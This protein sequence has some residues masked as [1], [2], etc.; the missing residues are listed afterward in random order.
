MKIEE[1]RDIIDC[2]P[3][4]RTKFYY[5]KD[6]YALMLLVYA[7]GDGMRIH[8]IKR[9]RFGRLIRKPMVEKIIRD[10]GCG[11]L[12]PRELGDF[13]PDRYH[14]Y[15]LTLG[16]WG[17]CK[18]WSRFYN[19]TSRPGWNLVLHLN[20][21]AE[22]NR[23]FY[24]LVKPRNPYVFQYL[25]HPVASSGRHTLAWARIDMDLDAGEALIEE[26]QT[27]WIRKAMRS[28]RIM[29]ACENSAGNRQRYIPDDVRNLGCDSV[30]L[31]R[32]LDLTLKPHMQVWDEAMLASAI[33]FLK[34]EIGLDRI[35]YHTFEFGSQWKRICGS[36]PPRSL[37]TKLP[38]R[39]C[40]T[41]TSRVPG[42]LKRKN[43]RIRDHLIKGGHRQFYLL[44]LAPFISS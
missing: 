21:A 26:I 29:A 33:W 16:I 6:R 18:R 39:F 25:S 8:D 28:S 19:Q 3:R 43:N 14:C 12:T 20:F 17:G 31:N 11:R 34:E 4:G 15:L 36:N 27:D 35:Y 13:W 2:L 10:S 41:R 32:Y 44:D 5:F 42:F 1:I 37:Y 22:H 38:D 30:A 9:S 7:V 24:R 23:S 40:F